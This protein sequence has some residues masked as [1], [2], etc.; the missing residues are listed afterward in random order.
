LKKLLGWNA[1]FV[2]ALFVIIWAGLVWLMPVA[3]RADSLAAVSIVSP[4]ISVKQPLK[5]GI[6]AFRSGDYELAIQQFTEALE[7][8]PSS[9]AYSNRCLAEIHLEDYAT[10]IEDCTQALQLNSKEPESYLNR[11]LAYH[12]IGQPAEAIA[13]YDRLL[14]LKPHDFRA[15]YNRGLAQAD[16]QAYREA[17]VDYGEAIRQVTPLDHLTLA[18][19]HNDRG[20]AELWL[21]H[22]PQ[23]IAS[24]TQ[25][26]Q[27][28]GSD[29]RA[30]YNR[31]C[32]YHQQGQLAAALRDFT[33]VLQIAPDHAQAYLSRGLIQQQQGNLE[34][35][36]ADLQTAA[37][38]FNTQGAN[39][40]YL[41]TLQ[42]IQKL[43]VTDVAVG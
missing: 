36:L 8:A 7:I 43:R 20:L 18:E 29:L 31:G 42:L 14:Q 41:Q 19:I 5:D 9:A 33:Q 32:T 17:I 34:A 37:Q 1:L 13:D 40:A 2:N 15:Y 10:A 27:F 11:G 23:A 22:W 3:A 35:A 12:R 25:A 21:E 38:Y 26:I 28:N 30:H 4:E 16:Q 39:V 6:T 24:F